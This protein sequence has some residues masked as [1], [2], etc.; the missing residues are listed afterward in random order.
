M[1]ISVIHNFISVKYISVIQGTVFHPTAANSS[2]RKMSIV[3]LGQPAAVPS[4]IP[5]PGGT[6]NA[7]TPTSM[8]NIWAEITK[9]MPMEL[10]GSTG[11]DS[12]IHRKPRK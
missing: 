5:E 12:T 9:A 3:T 8:A 10:N 1:Y 7:I 11:R 6:R 4:S 2:V